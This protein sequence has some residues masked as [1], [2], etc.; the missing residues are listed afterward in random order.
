MISSSSQASRELGRFGAFSG[1]LKRSTS[2]PSKRVVHIAR[3]E[4]HQFDQSRCRRGTTLRVCP[5]VS[6]VNC[7]WWLGLL[8]IRQ[9]R[10]LLGF[11]TCSGCRDQIGLVCEAGLAQKGMSQPVRRQKT[12]VGVKQLVSC[13]LCAAAQL[14]GRLITE[15]HS[16]WDCPAQTLE[17]GI[18]VGCASL[19]HVLARRHPSAVTS[20]HAL[21]IP[22]PG[23]YKCSMH[24]FEHM[25]C[26][27]RPTSHP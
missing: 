27:L 15:L 13:F 8:P 18:A 24:V 21:W 14:H 22:F 23:R 19:L 5:S 17:N 9:A 20:C 6:S 12:Y 26:V 11:P 10:T 16:Q 25:P 7:T 4:V 3:L 1:D 2:C